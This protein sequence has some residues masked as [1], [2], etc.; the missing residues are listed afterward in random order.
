MLEADRRPSLD[1]GSFG[2]SQ[3]G[4]RGC[5]DLFLASRNPGG[6]LANDLEQIIRTGLEEV[7][8]IALFVGAERFPRP[9][10]REVKIGVPARALPLPDIG[11][12]RPFSHGM[13]R[14]VCF[15]IRETIEFR[16]TRN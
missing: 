5:R 9:A 1:L 6:G 15:L 2:P 14:V 16:N 3:E 4:W 12:D 8:R 10:Q 13:Y 11:C 7:S